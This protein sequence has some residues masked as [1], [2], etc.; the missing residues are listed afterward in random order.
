MAVL[1]SNL[2]GGW[3][4][5]ML[6]TRVAFPFQVQSYEEAAASATAADWSTLEACAMTSCIDVNGSWPVEHVAMT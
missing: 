4:V 1:P 3:K 6:S 5:E 2:R